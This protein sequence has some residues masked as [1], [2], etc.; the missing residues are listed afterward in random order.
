MLELLSRALKQNISMEITLPEGTV[1]SLL[2]TLPTGPRNELESLRRTLDVTREFRTQLERERQ[3]E[4]REIHAR[5]AEATGSRVVR[6]VRKAAETAEPIRAARVHG[7]LPAHLHVSPSGAALGAT[8][9]EERSAA[10]CVSVREPVL[11]VERAAPAREQAPAWARRLLNQL[12]PRS[13]VTVF[14]W[15]ANPALML[16]VKPSELSPALR[17]AHQSIMTR[18]G[19]TL[20]KQGYKAPPRLAREWFSGSTP[21]AFPPKTALE[22]EAIIYPEGISSDEEAMVPVGHA[23]SAKNRPTAALPRPAEDT[24]LGTRAGYDPPADELIYANRHGPSR[25]KR[26][27]P[28]PRRSRRSSSGSRAAQRSQLAPSSPSS[29]AGSPTS[30]DARPAGTRVLRTVVRRK[31]SIACRPTKSI[32]SRPH[33]IFILG[34]LRFCR[35][36]FVVPR[37]VMGPEPD[38]LLGLD[39]IQAIHGQI[40]TTLSGWC[41]RARDSHYREVVVPFRLRTSLGSWSA[42]SDL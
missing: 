26:S 31:S 41:L 3:R 40:D 13:T 7:D 35:R 38:I 20:H 24:P 21:T 42:C 37:G 12:G 9:V 29:E 27:R 17:A 5:E 34:T 19:L 8:A 1:T 6:M 39:A 36:V 15:L 32:T 23:L 2:S 14:N 30:R 18:Y 11:L 33:R 22:A 28:S 4:L 16:T 10:P 25:R